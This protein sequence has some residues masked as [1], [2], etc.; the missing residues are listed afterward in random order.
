MPSPTPT[1]SAGVRLN[2]TSAMLSALDALKHAQDAAAAVRVDPWEFAVRLPALTSGGLSE[3][4]VRRLLAS[5]LAEHAQEQVRPTAARRS[6]RRLANLALTDRTCFILRR[7]GE[8]LLKLSGGADAPA[9]LVP[10][11]D[12]ARRQL[13]YGDQL[14]KWYRVPANCQEILLAAF[15]EDRWPPR[16]DDPLPRMT[17]IDPRERLHEAVKRLNGAQ[18][19]PLLV[20]QRDGT[21]LGVT[22][23]AEVEVSGVIDDEFP[24]PTAIISANP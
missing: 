13:W 3:T 12:G 24:Q 22:W 18:I 2:P 4:D 7:A 17:N 20:F 23:A 21:G 11:W 5:G 14:V 1:G 15:E 9:P 6:F 8:Q 10:R 16:I 19:T